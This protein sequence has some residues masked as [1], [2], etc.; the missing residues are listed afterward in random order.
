MSSTANKHL[1]ETFY[2][3]FQAK[4]YTG[5]IACYQPDVHFSDPVFTNLKGNQA[6]A[7][8]HM[9]C[10]RG[11]DLTLEY[12]QVQATDTTGRAHW[13][14]RYTFSA[15]KRPVHNIIDATFEFQDGKIIKHTDV[16]NLWRW[17]RMALGPAGVLLGWTPIIQNRVRQTARQGLDAFIANHPEYQ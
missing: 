10:E 16:F 12:N 5:M 9:L 7:M 4:D 6:K 13:E 1:I 17:T 14:A 11:R 3:S 15:S 8:W 2:S